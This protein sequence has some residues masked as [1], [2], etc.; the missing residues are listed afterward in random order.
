LLVATIA[1]TVVYFK[2]LNT[3]GLHANETMTTIPDNAA[4]V[5][6]F[7]NEDSFYDIFGGNQLFASVIGQQQLAELDTLRG[8]LMA[9]PALN[10]FFTGQ[11]TF[12]SLH[13]G[14]DYAIDLLLTIAAA[15]GFKP[16]DIDQL[17]K[18]ANKNLLVTAT[19]FNGK[20][21]Y[22]IYSGILKKRFYLVNKEDGIYSGSFSKDVVEQSAKYTAQKDKKVF[23]QLPDQQNT[24]SLANV[25]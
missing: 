4:L 15:K 1:I 22:I 21:G 23:M 3:P 19:L 10:K 6:E 12:I 14:R 17:E 18:P 16:D 9:I 13:P 20:K 8:Q 24:N 25:H 7:N 5:F 11:N 2:N